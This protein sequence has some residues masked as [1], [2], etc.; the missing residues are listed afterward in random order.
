[1]TWKDSSTNPVVR[2]E[3]TGPLMLAPIGGQVS[4]RGIYWRQPGGGR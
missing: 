3:I 4:G 2:H 1:M